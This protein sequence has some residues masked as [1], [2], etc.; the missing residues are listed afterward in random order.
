MGDAWY[1]NSKNDSIELF[2]GLRMKSYLENEYKNEKLEESRLPII[3]MDWGEVKLANE[4]S[5]K[6]GLDTAYRRFYKSSYNSKDSENLIMLGDTSYFSFIAVDTSAS[7]YRSPLDDEWFFLMRAG[8]STRYYW[9]DGEDSKIVSRYEWVK[10]IGLKPVAKL[11]PNGFGLYDMMGIA[12]D[13]CDGKRADNSL[14]PERAFIKEI[15]TLK[16]YMATPNATKECEKKGDAEWKCTDI[17]QKPV[18]HTSQANYT[19]LR[20][21]RKTPKLHKL[22]KF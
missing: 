17:E 11:Q 6:E 5:K 7:G 1:Y 22:E 2:S 18:L 10:P 15:G 4:R 3:G 13:Y 14:S 19:G 12:R 16:Q 21:I 8:A 20:F 9:G